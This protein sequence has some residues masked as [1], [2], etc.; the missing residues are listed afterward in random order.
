MT[1][2]KLRILYLRDILLR[3]T[4]RD[5][6]MTAER[7]IAQLEELAGETVNRKT[8]YRDIENLRLYGMDIRLTR[9]EPPGF[10]VEQRDFDL[11]E[12]KMLVDAVQSSKFISESMSTAL[13]RRLGNL[14][15][16]YQAGLLQRQVFVLHRGK[17]QN[18]TALAN[19]DTIHHAIH[20]NHQI[21]FLYA[22]WTVKKQM[23]VRRGGALYTVSPWAL[24]WVNENYYM[25]AYSR[26]DEAIRHY[27]VDKMREVQEKSRNREGEDTFR[28]FDL[29]AF[30][31]KT[32][33]MFGG[34][35]VK[36]TLRCSNDL[37]G[38]ILDRF[39]TDVMI[40]P[41]GSEHFRVHVN[42]ALSRQ[43]FG[44]L[45]GIGDQIKIINPVRVVHDYE[46]YLE[47]LLKA[48]RE[49]DN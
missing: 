35:D 7:L 15:S 21:V 8:I 36:V 27:R 42:I 13:I 44:W 22:E 23:R 40:I 25:I 5:H 39:G 2:V 11:G 24:V 20:E 10:Y 3:E 1:R 37:A 43:F 32:F 30:T 17:T 14:T 16:R 12:L 48:Y 31:K 45:A 46:N 47:K 38:V 6:P 34:E 26:D 41:D 33:G 29:P 9:A 49:G 19:V 4:D 28:Q 18:D